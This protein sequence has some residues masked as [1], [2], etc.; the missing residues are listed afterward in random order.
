M[1]TRSRKGLGRWAR[2]RPVVDSGCM[3]AF[4]ELAQREHAQTLASLVPVIEDAGIGTGASADLDLSNACPE[5]HPGCGPGM[6]ELV[7]CSQR[8]HARLPTLRKK[9]IPYRE[10]GSTFHPIH[11]RSRVR[12]PS[13]CDP[14]CQELL[15][16]AAHAYLHHL[17]SVIPAQDRSS[18]LCAQ[19][20]ATTRCQQPDSSRRT[21]Q[22]HLNAV[23]Q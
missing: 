5:H 2:F 10:D 23:C 19:A 20:S 8:R 1:E 3:S 16:Q 7:S 18:I 12:R 15:R 4:L 13:G 9:Q 14:A 11:G 17:R 6:F 22:L 21:N